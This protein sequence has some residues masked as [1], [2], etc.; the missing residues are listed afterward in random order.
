[1]SWPDLLS[2]ALL[3]A[4]VWLWFASIKAREI[5]VR[6]AR[7]A[8]QTR[9]LQLLDDT[10]AIIRMKPARDDEGQ[11]HWQRSYS[12]EY[13]VT[14]ENRRSGH[15]DMLGLKVLDTELGPRILRVVSCEAE[16]LPCGTAQGTDV[17]RGTSSRHPPGDPEG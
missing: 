5:A 11:L 3:G 17:E 1:M 2:I 6:A 8:C 7:A 9:G 14:G 15:L 16:N 4:A 13:S 12:F 10:V